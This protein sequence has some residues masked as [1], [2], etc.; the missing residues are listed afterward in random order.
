MKQAIILGFVNYPRG[1]A[2]A[3]YVQYLSLALIDLGYT[4]TI[5]SN[6]NNDCKELKKKNGGIDI[7]IMDVKP[8]IIP[9]KNKI[10]HFIEYNF[11]LGNIMADI[12]DECN[13]SGGDV[14][15]TYGNICLFQEKVYKRARKYGAKTF[16]CITEHFPASHYKHGVASPYYWRYCYTMAV[17]I[18]KAKSI[19]PISRHLQNYYRQKGCNTLLLP[20]LADPYEYPQQQKVDDGIYRI[21]FPSNGF[22]KD[23]L[24]QMLDGISLLSDEEL[25]KIEIHFTGIGLKKLKE[26]ADDKFLSM[27]GKQV[28]VHSWLEYSELVDLYQKMDFLLLAREDSQM[29]RA[30][31]PSKVPEVMCYGVIPIVSKVGDYTDLYLKNGANSIVFEGCSANDILNALRTTIALPQNKKRKL[32]AGARLC[33][34]QDFIIKIG[35]RSYRLFLIRRKQI[36]RKAIFFANYGSP[37][38]GNF[39]VSLKLLE[40]KLNE[41]DIR[42]IYVFPTRTGERNWVNQLKTDDNDIVYLPDNR[43]QAIR[44]LRKILREVIFVHTHFIN[45]E[46]ML[47]LKLARIT[48]GARCVVIHHIHNHY[49]KSSNK[50]KYLLKRWSIKSDL[51]LACGSGVC[52]S[53]HQA[54]L[55]NEAT[56]ID[57]GIDFRR[58]DQYEEARFDKSKIQILMFGFDYKRKG[59]DL[60]VKACEKLVNEG[61]KLQLNI[62]LSRNLET[63]KKEIS[64]L[65]R[66]IPDW[67]SLLPPR[68]D[69]ATYYKAADLFISPSREEGLCY[70]LIEAAYCG[71]IVVASYISGQYE[72]EIPQIVWCKKENSND[73]AR[74]IYDVIK[75]S[76]DDIKDKITRQKEAVLKKYSVSRWV[77]DVMEYYTSHKII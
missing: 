28:I 71:C 12:L 56:Y 26:N 67:I 3:N 65:M 32:E 43:L 74:A 41:N 50:I 21:V 38:E 75:L 72:L 37:Y 59:V 20:I 77:D 31:F 60:A 4:V 42:V 62:S 36:M 45:M 19:L 53:I 64:S 69:I 13:L 52:D 10:T 68:N 49:E 18:P 1:S 51:M 47:I 5:Y 14:V 27:I 22:V 70:S 8:I 57:N 25:S 15:I 63:V 11:M 73:L 33:A 48:S 58:L 54:G 7:R 29:T 35:K 61:Y 66:N 17:S 55:T 23:A 46:Q 2:P 44:K 6:I 34:K 30:N 9:S 24:K 16:A 40:K 76:Q 39:I